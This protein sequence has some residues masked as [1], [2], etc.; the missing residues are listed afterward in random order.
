M[1]YVELEL[2]GYRRLRLAN[3]ERIKITPKEKL[4]LI[5]GTNGSGKSS[6]LKEMS[7]LPAV[8]QNYN[9]TGKKRILIESKGSRYELISS[10]SPTQRHNFLKNGEELNLGGTASV[11]K[12]LVRQEF[13]IT[14]DIHELIT[15]NIV[16]NGMG[17]AERRYWFTRLSDTSYNYAL[18]VY[19]KLKEKHRDI[20]GAIKLN[21][22]RAVQEANKLLSEAQEKTLRDEIQEFR[23]ILEQLL[24]LKSPTKYF[25]T[26]I[27]QQIILNEQKLS[28]TARQIMRERG[29]FLN[30]EGFHSTDDIDNAIIQFS[31]TTASLAY[32]I[33]MVSKEITTSQ[34][35][36][37]A[38]TRANINN[39]QEIDTKRTELTNQIEALKKRV[40]T[41]C[42]F[43]DPMNS[44]QSIM[45]VQDTLVDILTELPP[46][47]DKRFSRDNFTLAQTRSATLVKQ[48]EICENKIVSYYAHKKT[49]EE[50]RDK[51]PIECPA[52]K[53]QWQLG[54]NPERFNEITTAIT[55]FEKT[56]TDLQQQQKVNNEYLESARQYFT[57]YNAYANIAKAW[58]SLTPLWNY[59]S[60]KELLLNDPKAIV[61]F[62]DR[63][64][65]S[66]Q[67]QIQVSELYKQLTELNELK[68]ATEKLGSDHI[69]KIK[70]RIAELNETLFKQNEQLRNT[71]VKIQRLKDYKVTVKLM[72]QWSEES[73]K[74]IT[75]QTNNLE[76]LVEE[77]KQEMINNLIR[78]VQIELSK[79]EQELSHVNV[80]KGLVENI[81][82]QL[83]ELDDEAYV[84]HAM[85]K[86]LSPSE[87]LIAKGLLGFINNFVKQMNS[88]IRKVWL[89]PM[90]IV[91][92]LPTEDNEVDLDYKFS[93]QVNDYEPI[94]DIKLASSAMSEIINLAFV[95]VAMKYLGL[96]DAPLVLDEFTKSFDAA[97]RSA[98]NV[99]ISNLILQSEFSQI[100]IVSHFAD[101]YGSLTNADV[102]VLCSKNIVLPKNTTFNQHVVIN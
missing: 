40:G 53:Y 87:G 82:K 5:L 91:P 86:E 70:T 94:P 98:A 56:Q 58:P 54:Y 64:K 72:R 73:E 15:G 2:V 33:D 31:S 62:I 46:N 24:T 67:I 48:I 84:L 68:V 51:L 49:M 38:L 77:T 52:C 81:K 74:L 65:G 37:D 22:S 23:A 50:A 10:F 96:T 85:V 6:L 89:Y 45:S 35:T 26:D 9:K 99:V 29:K 18:A 8:S 39:F 83:K 55:S 100:F 14:Q 71:N 102:T 43:S 61:Y 93:L 13:N 59:I 11:Q 7:P 63:L 32:T 47:D 92:C 97:H 3:I 28:N 36:I 1:K 34:E 27:E 19:Q 101:S 60:E 95:I 79:R 30:H 90:E 80:Q 76:L 88:F 42:S 21:Q 57:L 44:F 25:R 4:Q 78:H 41:E 17:P 12:E 16:F 20:L 75:D 69:E 66:I